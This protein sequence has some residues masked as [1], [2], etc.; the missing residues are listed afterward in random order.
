M[1]FANYRE[2]TNIHQLYF[3]KQEQATLLYGKEALF[4]QEI[5]ENKNDQ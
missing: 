4:I 3:L 5:S 1:V 2:N